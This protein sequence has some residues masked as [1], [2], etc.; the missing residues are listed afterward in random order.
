M[1]GAVNP[2]AM[3]RFLDSG[4]DA[5]MRDPPA[6]PDSCIRTGFDHF[7]AAVRGHVTTVTAGSLRR[8]STCHM[9]LWIA[10]SDVLEDLMMS[11]GRLFQNYKHYKL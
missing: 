9:L 7:W 11:N 3:S 6:G 1:S 10:F 2:K 4:R 5:V 8:T